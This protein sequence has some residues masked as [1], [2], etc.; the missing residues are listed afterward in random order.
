M[1]CAADWLQ[2]S[3]EPQGWQSGSALRNVRLKPSF[4]QIADLQLSGGCANKAFT[5]SSV[6]WVMAGYNVTD[7][8]ARY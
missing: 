7:D 2:R 6:R 3:T 1:C 5:I 8:T 4:S